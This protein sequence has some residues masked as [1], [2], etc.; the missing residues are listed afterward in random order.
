MVL[1]ISSIERYLEMIKSNTKN[2]SIK[3]WSTKEYIYKKS[4]ALTDMFLVTG[5][6]R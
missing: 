4:G 1:L 5:R 6:G 2:I 3:K